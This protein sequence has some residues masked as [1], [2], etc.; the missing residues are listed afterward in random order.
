MK[1]KNALLSLCAC[2]AINCATTKYAVVKCPIEDLGPAPEVTLDTTPTGDVLI[3]ATDALK[4][5]AWLETVFV[6]RTTVNQCPAI[7][8]TRTQPPM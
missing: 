7:Q 2:L 1:L 8:A 5:A 6:Y 3:P 4:L